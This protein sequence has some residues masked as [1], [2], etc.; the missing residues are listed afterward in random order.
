MQ[1]IGKDVPLGRSIITSGWLHRTKDTVE[2]TQ[3]T[4]HSIRSTQYRVL[5]LK[6]TVIKYHACDRNLALSNVGLYAECSGADFI[7]IHIVRPFCSS[8]ARIL[9]LV[10]N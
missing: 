4:V 9:F 5:L 2:R 7:A 3:C 6:L 10:L 1:Y 8:C